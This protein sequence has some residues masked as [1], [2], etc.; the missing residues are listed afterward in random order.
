MPDPLAGLLDG[1]NEDQ[2]RAALAVSGP[3]VIHAGAGTGKTTTIV[4]R[5]AVAIASG[6]ADPRT[7]LLVTFT[8]KAAGELAT[9]VAGLG[10]PR[11]AARTFHSAA[12]AQLRHFWPRA[13]P[14]VLARD[15]VPRGADPT[16]VPAIL[17]NP[18]RI[19]GRLVRALPGGFAHRP[20]KDLVTEIGWARSRGLDPDTYADAIGGREPPVPLDLFLRV[21]RGY[22]RAKRAEGAIDFDDMLALTADLLAAHPEL[23]AEVR[24]RYAW[25]CVDEYQDTNPVQQRLLDTWLGDRTDICVVGDEDQTIY[26]FAGASAAHLADFG[27]RYPAAIH[28]ALRENHRSTPEILTLANRLIGATGR[29]KDLVATRPTGPWPEIRDHADDGAEADAIARTIAAHR[30]RGTAAAEIAVLVRLGA[31]LPPIEDALRRARIAFRVRG[32]RFFERAEV[33]AARAALA[34]LPAE[35]GGPALARAAECVTTDAAAPLRDAP[36]AEAREQV[37]ALDTLAALIRDH[38]AATADARPA[39]V[40]A[41][42]DARAAAEAT[43]GTDAVVLSTL[44]AAKGLEWDVVLLPGCAEGLLPVAQALDDPA[45][46]AEERR[47]L[48]VGIT[49]ARHDLVLS[50]ARHRADGGG[51]PR[52]PSRFLADLRPSAPA[53]R[54]ARAGAAPAGLAVGRTR[55]TRELVSVHVTDPDALPPD[56]AARYAALRTWRATRA[57]AD[58]VPA[59]VIGHNATLAASTDALGAVAGMGPARVARYGTEILAALAGARD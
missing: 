43:A 37:A 5:T 30:A 44:H 57:A 39:T 23:V 54:G 13:T 29:T 56:A 6:A 41:D 9:R 28:V 8:E 2:R 36:G 15:L 42:L 51:R 46:V 18:Y 49:R 3:V 27:A 22:A 58:G 33:R 35:L 21:F 32:R 47:L 10:L 40:V 55:A 14:W 25:F 11:V 20:A 31:Q 16:V 38:L 4:R 53:V 48:Y 19:V 45:A 1:L 7:I 52:R 34:A 12:L 26:S 59:Y 17:D 50:W 24:A